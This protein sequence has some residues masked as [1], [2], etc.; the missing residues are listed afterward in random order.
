MTARRS[1]AGSALRRVVPFDDGLVN[2]G[3]QDARSTLLDWYDPR[4]LHH[5][6]LNLVSTLD[7]RAAGADG[8]SESLTSR[9]DRTILGVIR[10]LSDVVLVGAETVR[11][12]GYLR[13]KRAALAIVSAS[14]D[15]DGHRLSSSVVADREDHPV[16]IFTTER[17]AAR[18][19]KRLEGAHVR[20]L[21][22]D[23]RIDPAEIIAAL[24]RLGLR[25]IVAEGGP[26]LAA[27]LLEARLVDEL[28]L[29]VMPR[30]GG[31]AL[32]VL[33]AEPAPVI[34][35]HP[36]LLLVDETGAQFGR[37]RVSRE[38]SHDDTAPSQREGS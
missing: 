10:E 16:L 1:T 6:R 15:V 18:A 29:T 25:R 5:L 33:T 28:C 9:A 35:V 17:G 20:V 36:T 23:E 30:L 24:R 38:S 21:D 27:Q 37:W 32:P 7:G 22:G 2:L 12:E 4:A 8:T 34:S 11:R 3:D 13:P 26:R 31:P 19:R 14:G